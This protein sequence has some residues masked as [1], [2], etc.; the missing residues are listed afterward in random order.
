MQEKDLQLKRALRCALFVLLLGAVGMEKM[1]GSYNFNAVCQTGQTLYYNI[2][3]AENHYVELTYPGSS[4]YNG[5]SGFTKP[6]GDIVL[7][8]SVQHEGVT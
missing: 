6:T 5:W 4:Q 2:V 1:Y 8:E 7:P 3:D